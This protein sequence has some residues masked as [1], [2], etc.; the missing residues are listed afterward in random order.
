[1]ERRRSLIGFVEKQKIFPGSNRESTSCGSSS[2]NFI[3][4]QSDHSWA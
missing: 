4:L 2:L 1:M 3:N